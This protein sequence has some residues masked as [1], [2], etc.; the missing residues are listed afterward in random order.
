MKIVQCIWWTIWRERN[1]ICFE[2]VQNSLHSLQKIKMNCLSLFIFGVNVLVQT[3]DI[4][5]VF[6]LFIGNN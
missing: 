2:N 5:D 4:C 1:N 6:R 3:E